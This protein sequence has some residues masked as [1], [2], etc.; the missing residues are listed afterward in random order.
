MPIA[1]LLLQCAMLLLL[2]PLL[3]FHHCCF[4]HCSRNWN[5]GEARCISRW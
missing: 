1:V 2:L 3:N 5:K 4:H